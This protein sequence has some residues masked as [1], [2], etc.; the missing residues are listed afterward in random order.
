VSSPGE[1][2]IFDEVVLPA[3]AVEA[4]LEEWRADYVPGANARGLAL[5]GVW[6][7]FTEHPDHA[8]VVIQWSVATIPGFFA[9]RGQGGADPRVTD[10]WEQTD[11]LAISRSR[12][13]LG[14]AGVAS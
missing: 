8:V 12:R 6:R 14:D 2:T 3:D 10:F 9:S 5:Q 1:V 13:V 4:W 7:G 11:E